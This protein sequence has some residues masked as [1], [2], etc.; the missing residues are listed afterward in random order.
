MAKLPIK[1]GVKTGFQDT[2]VVN[3]GQYACETSSKPSAVASNRRERRDARGEKRPL[4]PLGARCGTAPS[5]PPLRRTR[6]KGGE[7]VLKSDEFP[8]PVGPQKQGMIDH[9][10][11]LESTD[12]RV[13]ASDSTGL[14]WWLLKTWQVV[15]CWMVH[16]FVGDLGS[17]LVAKGTRRKVQCSV[18][19]LVGPCQGSECNVWHLRCLV[20]T[21]RSN[22]VYLL[23]FI[24]LWSHVVLQASPRS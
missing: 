23:Q 13:P 19:V 10:E 16:V 21:C 15:T 24:M 6:K 18:P 11:Y 9:D 3:A 22:L 1:T 7:M 2:L 17:C 4:T 14:L 20:Q 8:E 12:S 5:L